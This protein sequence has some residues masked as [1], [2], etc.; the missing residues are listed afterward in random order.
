MGCA[1]S[2]TGI[3]A[4]EIAGY[5]SAPGVLSEKKT[6]EFKIPAFESRLEKQPVFTDYV[7]CHGYSWRLGVYPFGDGSRGDAQR[8]KWVSL[9][10]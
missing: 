2:R 9:Y 4:P 1:A 8:T 6:L 7:D 5:A 3:T 10:Y